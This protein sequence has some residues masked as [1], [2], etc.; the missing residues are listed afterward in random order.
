MKIE[1]HINRLGNSS[2]VSFSYPLGFLI[3][4]EKENNCVSYLETT[5]LMWVLAW[6]LSILFYL[7][8][9]REY[10]YMQIEYRKL[11]VIQTGA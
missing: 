4:K 10:N 3:S 2:A 5:Q 8:R 1:W 6:M 11:E 7:A 9:I